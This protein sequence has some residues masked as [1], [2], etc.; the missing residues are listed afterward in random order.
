MTE[1]RTKREPLLTLDYFDKS[2]AY[3]Q[4]EGI[5]KFEKK[6]SGEVPD[7]KQ[8]ARLRYALFKKKLH[9]IIS[10]YSRGDAVAELPAMLP[11]VIEALALYQAE[12]LHEPF[13]LAAADDYQTALWLVSLAAVLKAPAALNEQLVRLINST[14]QDALL[15]A[16]IKKLVPAAEQATIQLKH[17]NLVQPL[18]AA[19]QAAT[20]QDKAS[21]LRQFLSAW[22]SSRSELYWHDNHKGPDGGGF[23]GYWALEVAGVATLFGIDDGPIRDMPFYPEDLVEF[24]RA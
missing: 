9:L 19:T 21:H 14:G 20:Q 5:P 16:M 3:E 7:K 22:Y 24:A 18:Y 17:A 1:H 13:N 10:R 2:I 6:L 15:D 23:F 12:E 11:P 8:R 4:T